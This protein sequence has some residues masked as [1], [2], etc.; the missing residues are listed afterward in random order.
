MREDLVKDHLE[1]LIAGGRLDEHDWLAGFED[2]AEK[3]EA[4][5]RFLALQSAMGAAAHHDI[6]KIWA[7]FD[8]GQTQAKNLVRD[9]AR[10]TASHLQEMLDRE[11]ES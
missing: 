3:V 1:F 5:R 10:S 9:I 2:R 8:G 7:I 6:G 4:G 11:S